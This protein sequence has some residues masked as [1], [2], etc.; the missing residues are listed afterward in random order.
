MLRLMIRKQ[1]YIDDD[2]EQS[3]KRLARTTRLAEAEHVRR[4][5]R[6]YV[7]EQQGDGGF[8]ALVALAEDGDHEDGPADAAAEHDHYSYGTPKRSG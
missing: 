7:A 4:A 5:L 8:D 1:L 3:L 6:A 2:L